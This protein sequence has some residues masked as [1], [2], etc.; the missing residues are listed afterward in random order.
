MSTGE[1]A[2]VESSDVDAAAFQTDLRERVDGPFVVTYTAHLPFP[3]NVP[4]NLG[5]AIRVGHFRDPADVET[6][7][8]DAYVNIRVFDDARDGFPSWSAGT[9]AAIKQ[10]YNV[11]L[12]IDDQERFGEETLVEHDQWVT[13][14]T[15]YATIDGEDATADP[16]FTFHRC[17]HTFN[18]FLRVTLYLT[19]YIGLR[20]IA[21]QNLQPVVLIGAVPLK[22]R[23][24][25]LLSP[26]Y[27]A[28]PEPGGLPNAPFFDETS[29]QQCIIAVLQ[30]HPYLGA[31]EWRARAQHAV[32]RT[33]DAADAIISFQIAIESMLFDTYRM[34]LVDEGLTADE[35]EAQLK[36]ELQFKRLL[37]YVIPVR[38]KG[39]WNITEPT[40]PVGRY[41][42]D[43]YQVRNALVHRGIRPHGGQAQA[44]QTAFRGL[45]DYLEQCMWHMHRTYPRTL[46]ARVGEEQL[47]TR[48]WMNRWLRNTI[49]EINEGPQ[50]FFWPWDKRVAKLSTPPDSADGTNTTV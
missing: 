45:R 10:F 42:N 50:P 46:L 41:W 13:L 17:L 15:P 40:T 18:F 21:Y 8:P 12:P 22:T 25:T 29:F 49:Q 5:H 35:I 20:P 6:F 48:G 26:M 1:P 47:T 4:V 34:L 9:T 3:L 19:G 2:E 39:K 43:L 36:E 28:A 32:R 14:E 30:N 38:L 37:T 16:A 31:I 24:W 44:A 7:G 11:D 27:M 23:Q 33:G